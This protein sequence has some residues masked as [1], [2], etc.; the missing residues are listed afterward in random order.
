[1]VQSALKESKQKN[2]MINVT[3]KQIQ[4][5]PFK[6]LPEF[7]LLQKYYPKENWLIMG[8]L[9]HAKPTSAETQLRHFNEVI[10]ALG[11][12]NN[13]FGHRLH[14][15]AR[16]GGGAG[17]SSHTHI[18]F[19]LSKHQITNGHKFSYTPEQAIDFILKQ[20]TKFGMKEQQRIYRFDSSRPGV[21]Y[22]L[23][24]ESQHQERKVEISQS[25][26]QL[27]KKEQK[28]IQSKQKEFDDLL[29]AVKTGMRNNGMKEV[30]IDG[31]AVWKNRMLHENFPR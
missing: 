9:T 25:L 27:I 2:K 19:L 22:V 18:H 29:N 12:P 11:K 31:L 1:L 30:I 7:E 20:W 14:W 15:I 16:I 3:E 24:D 6:T 23:R 26:R 28:V 4:T 10:H 17:T 8:T 21:E 13:T 5:A